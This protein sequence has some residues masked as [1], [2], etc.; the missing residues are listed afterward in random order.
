MRVF[1]IGAPE[2]NDLE[3]LSVISDW[4]LYNSDTGWFNHE[5]SKAEVKFVQRYVL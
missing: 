4:L 3:P 5:G 2:A 1:T